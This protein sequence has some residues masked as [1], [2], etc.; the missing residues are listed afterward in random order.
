VL[1][2]G[3]L[4]TGQIT[5]VDSG[6]PIPYVVVEVYD[7]HH[8]NLRLAETV[9]DEHGNYMTNHV[10]AGNYKVRF[11]RSNYL[12]QY[13]GGGMDFSSATLVSV[14]QNLTTNASTSLLS[15]QSP[16]LSIRMRFPIV[17]RQ[18]SNQLPIAPTPFP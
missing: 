13:F 2:T 14:T 16:R 12:D 7:P 8:P 10:R 5:D 18:V 4:I 6:E 3:G 1:Q 11:S 9:A 17:L 15:L